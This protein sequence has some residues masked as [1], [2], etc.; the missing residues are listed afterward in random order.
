MEEEQDYRPIRTAKTFLQSLQT[1]FQKRDG[2][3]IAKEFKDLYFTASYDSVPEK[4]WLAAVNTQ[5]YADCEP[6]VG[7]LFARVVELGRDFAG[8]RAGG[9][10]S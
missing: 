4:N 5:A 9:R 3:R 6:N 10:W 7:A 1:A 2:D 8:E